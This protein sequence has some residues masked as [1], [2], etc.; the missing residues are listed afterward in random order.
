M[1]PA[2]R[3]PLPRLPTCAGLVQMARRACIRSS[4]AW[5]PLRIPALSRDLA[6]S[7]PTGPDFYSFSFFFFKKKKLI[8]DLYS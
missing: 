8:G 7:L 1:A 4:S 2:L 6:A 5:H 3:L